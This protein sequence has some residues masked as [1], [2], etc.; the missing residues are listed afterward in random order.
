MTVMAEGDI[1]REISSVHCTVK[2]SSQIRNNH[3]VLL[4]PYRSN[5]IRMFYQQSGLMKQDQVWF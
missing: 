2:H 3:S 5:F 4:T 1:D